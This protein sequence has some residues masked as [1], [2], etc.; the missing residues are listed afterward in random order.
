MDTRWGEVVENRRG[1]DSGKC[2]MHLTRGDRKWGPIA[3][4]R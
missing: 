2:Q 1:G 4:R 3:G